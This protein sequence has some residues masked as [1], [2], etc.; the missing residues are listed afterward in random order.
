MDLTKPTVC[1]VA[2]GSILY[3]CNGGFAV[4]EDGGTT[5]KQ[6]ATPA[7]PHGMAVDPQDRAVIYLSAPGRG[8]L[9][10]HDGG[11]TW[12]L[13]PGSPI[14]TPTSISGVLHNPLHVDLTQSS[15]I[16]YGTDNGMFV[17]R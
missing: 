11:A 6:V 9:K 14:I 1:N 2:G 4:S 17:S 13:L 7:S 10:S 15:T 8:V 5:W 3:I 16:Y 12:A